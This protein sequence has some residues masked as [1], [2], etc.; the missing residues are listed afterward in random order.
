MVSI[1]ELSIGLFV[2][3]FAVD[4]SLTCVRRE[5]REQ[6]EALRSTTE[7]NNALLDSLKQYMLADYEH[8]T[9]SLVADTLHYGISNGATLPASLYY[10][11]EQQIVIL[12]RLRELGNQGNVCHIMSPTDLHSFTLC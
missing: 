6:G 8:K 1:K 9:L 5:I 3:W 2:L 10:G 4:I 12:T 11:Q 7:K